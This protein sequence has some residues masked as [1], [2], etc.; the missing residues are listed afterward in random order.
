MGPAGLLAAAF[1]LLAPPLARPAAVHFREQFLDGG[2]WKERWVP[3]QHR[4]DYGAFRLTAGAFYGDRHLDQGLQTSQDLRFYALS[5]RFQPFSNQGRP[6]VVQYTVKHEQKIDCGGGYVKIFPTHLD[7]KN[8]SGESP[9][10]VMFGPDIC[11]SDTKTVH[12]ILRHRGRFHPIKKPIR[13]IVDGL[14]HLYTL[15]LNPDRSYRVKIDN[16]VVASGLLE[17]D[18]DFLPPRTLNDPA[19][20]K[21]ADWDDRA[22]MDDPGD[23]KPEDWDV[24]EFLV[25]TS[26]KKPRHWDDATQGDWRPPLLPNPRY[27][28][29]WRPRK[30]P[31]PKYKGVWPHP[32]IRNPDYA[33]DATLA[34]YQDLGVLGLD[35]WQVRSGTI[36][37]NFLIT[38]SESYA[39]EFGDETWGQTKEAEHRMYREQIEAEAAANR[40]RKAGRPPKKRKKKPPATRARKEEL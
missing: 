34:V 4:A 39:E 22:E 14:T 19:V 11:G 21:P 31:N 40:K 26:A 29:E 27:R 13:C 15:V 18:W 5:A 33:P 37:D 20:G 8:M 12:V 2:K 36:F 7:Q 17:D 16:T 35:L 38:D 23:A 25:D 1:L 32:Q 6:F 3:S 9:Y 28:G 10:Y 24:P 30:I